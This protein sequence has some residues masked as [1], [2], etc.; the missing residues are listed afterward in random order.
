M[1][2]HIAIG[3]TNDFTSRYNEIKDDVWDLLIQ[4]DKGNN[5]ENVHL[6]IECFINKLLSIIHNEKLDDLLSLALKVEAENYN[7]YHNTYNN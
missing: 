6:L 4:I 1:N 5:V 3:A 2:A 7:P